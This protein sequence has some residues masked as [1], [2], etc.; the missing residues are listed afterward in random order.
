MTL[1]LRSYTALMDSDSMPAGLIVLLRG[2][3]KNRHLLTF[4]IGNLIVLEGMN[5][6]FIPIRRR[7]GIVPR[8]SIHG[9]G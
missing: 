3:R 9:L 5:R 2:L 6:F 7:H 8:D 4:L 1:C